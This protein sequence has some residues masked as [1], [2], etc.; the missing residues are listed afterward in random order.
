[1]SSLFLFKISAICF[2]FIPGYIGD[3]ITKLA[4]GKPR[5]IRLHTNVWNSLK[6]LEK[7]IFTEWKF[8]NTNTLALIKSCSADD[9][10][11]FYIDIKTLDWQDYFANLAQGVRRYLH[12]EDP[13]SL[14]AA[15]RKD[16]W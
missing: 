11:Q 8:H 9:R 10:E 7:F 12:K 16:M 14:P 3:G 2:H 1:M 15:R 6:L 13:K 4:G 5:L